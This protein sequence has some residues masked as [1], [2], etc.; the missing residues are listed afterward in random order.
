VENRQSANRKQIQPTF[1]FSDLPA[2][3]FSESLLL[4]LMI[5]VLA[6]ARTELA[7]QLLGV[8]FLVIDGD[9]IVELVALGALEPNP[10]PGHGNFLFAWLFPREFNLACKKSGRFIL[11]NGGR[12]VKTAPRCEFSLHRTL[13]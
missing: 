9:A 5:R 13:V 12:F 7:H 8:E 11:A 1:P 2:L 10:F 6:R 4:D 3:L